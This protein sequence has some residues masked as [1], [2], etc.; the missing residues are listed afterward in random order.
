MRGNDGFTITQFFQVLKLVFHTLQ[1]Q[2]LFYDN[3]ILSGTKIAVI[4]TL[5]VHLFYDNSI[6]SGT[7]IDIRFVFLNLL[8]YDNSILSG[9]KI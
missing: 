9:T 2:V 3:S 5:S 1:S 8:F 7:K 4:D 6:L